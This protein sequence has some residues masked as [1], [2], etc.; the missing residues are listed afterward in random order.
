MNERTTITIARQM[1]SGGAYVGQIIAQRFKLKYI[2]REVLSLAAESLGVDEAAVEASRERLTSFWER[3]FGGLTFLPPDG[4]YNPPPLMRTYSDDELFRRFAEALRLIAE[5]EDCVIIGWGGAYILPCH[6]RMIN[7]YFH[8]PLK[9]RIKRVAKLYKLADLETAGRMVAD[10]DQMRR[11]YFSQMT[12]RDWACAD[13][14]HLCLDTSLFPLPE[15]ADRLTRFIARRLGIKEE[16]LGLEP[17][18]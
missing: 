16:T 12:G 1:G 6:A 7:I 14:Y 18:P 3:I 13:N 2:D 11:K 17:Q 4:P 15:L 8:A 9:Y 10:S 5:R